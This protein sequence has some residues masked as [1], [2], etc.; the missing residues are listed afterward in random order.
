MRSSVA[1]LVALGQ[2]P[3][4]QGVTVPQVK[5]F[6]V[7]LQKIEPSLTREEDIAFLPVFGQD[8]CFGLAWPLLHLIETAPDWLYPEAGLYARNLW[9]KTLLEYAK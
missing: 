3:G 6:E 4:E 9:G 7:A 8:N 5:E 1:Q 2:L